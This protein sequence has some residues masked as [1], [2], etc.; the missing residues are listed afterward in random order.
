[1]AYNR[2]SV[3]KLLNAGESFVFSPAF[4]NNPSKR[5]RFNIMT[6]GGQAYGSFFHDGSSLIKVGEVGIGLVYNNN[7]ISE[8]NK[9]NIYPSKVGELTIKNLTTSNR[10]VYISVEAFS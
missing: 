1:M 3:C 4:Q 6:D 2:G 8:Q 7:E 9:W 5:Y 10:K